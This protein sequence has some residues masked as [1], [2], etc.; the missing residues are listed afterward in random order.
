MSDKTTDMGQK[1]D[2]PAEWDTASNIVFIRPVKR[3][4]PEQMEKLEELALAGIAAG[5]GFDNC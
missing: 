4:S 1:T 5:R 2:L 3:P